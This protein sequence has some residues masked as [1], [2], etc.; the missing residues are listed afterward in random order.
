MLS[1]RCLGAHC[2]SLQVEPELGADGGEMETG[3][4]AEGN[5]LSLR[6]EEGVSSDPEVSGLVSGG[7]VMVPLTRLTWKEKYG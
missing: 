4:R 1:R 6:G 7:W 5:W 2:A 3:L